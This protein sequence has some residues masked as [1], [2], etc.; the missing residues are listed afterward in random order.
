[1]TGVGCGRRGAKTID[2][3][4]RNTVTG[5][6]AL[7]ARRLLA[8]CDVIEV[9]NRCLPI[10][11]SHLS[12]IHSMN[13]PSEGSSTMGSLYFGRETTTTRT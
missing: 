8:V 7:V 4:A 5:C 11:R 9:L 12:T 3:Q 13:T 1:V 6:R 2:D 10:A